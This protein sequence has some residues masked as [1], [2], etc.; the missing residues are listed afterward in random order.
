MRT[1]EGAMPPIH[2]RYIDGFD[3]L[4]NGGNSE[5]EAKRLLC[6]ACC[7]LYSI[8]RFP[9]STLFFSNAK[10]YLSICFPFSNEL[11]NVQFLCLF[12]VNSYF[13][14][15]EENKNQLLKHM[16]LLL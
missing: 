16:P 6:F 5:H 3:G 11:V 4:V 10:K 12:H 13:E 7:F 15:N 14:C 8:Y 1:A 9:S 2:Y